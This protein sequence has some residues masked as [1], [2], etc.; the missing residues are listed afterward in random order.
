MNTISEQKKRELIHL[1]EFKRIYQEFPQGTITP[2]EPIDF[3][4]SNAS[5]II[6]IEHTE[7]FI[8][9]S[10]SGSMMKRNEEQQKQVIERTQ[11]ELQKKGVN[12]YASLSW[13]HK[14]EVLKTRIESLSDELSE[15]IFNNIPEVGDS[16]SLE[17]MSRD[18]L[19]SEVRRIS[20]FRFENQD[21]IN[22]SCVRSAWNHHVS[23]REIQDILDSKNHK[24]EVYDHECDEAWLLI[25]IEG[26]YPSSIASLNDSSKSS[27][28][29]SDFDR[30]FIHDVMNRLVVELGIN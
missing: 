2:G 30:V 18:D 26:A 9:R 4:L 23:P 27:V 5:R 22:V 13:D 16:V 11:V 29:S 12:L 25:I 7:Y 3:K 19:P 20:V 28:Y 1:K 10:G 15:L 6:G 14:N 17:R 24:V 21:E 8:D